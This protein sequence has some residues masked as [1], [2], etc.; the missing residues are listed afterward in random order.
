MLGR[1]VRASAQGEWKCKCM[2]VGADARTV[3]PYMLC[4]N[5]LVH[6]F[7]ANLSTEIKSDA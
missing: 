7:T 3:R 2:I 6:L 5:Q 1:T 4:S